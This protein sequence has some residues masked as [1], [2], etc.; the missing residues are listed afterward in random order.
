MFACT[1][2]V[3]DCLGRRYRTRD[4]LS[5]DLAASIRCESMPETIDVNKWIQERFESYVYRG[6][7]SFLAGPTDR[8]NRAWARCMTLLEEERLKGG[9]LDVDTE[10][11][12]GIDEFVPG[13]ILE[14][15]DV[16][17]GLQTDQPL[18]R[19]CKPAGG[20]RMVESSCKA[21]GYEMSAEMLKVFTKYRKTHNMGVFD[22]YDDTMRSVR[23]AHLLTGLPDAYGR[24]RIIGDYRRVAVYGVDTLI[25]SKEMDKRGLGYPMTEDVIRLREELSEQINSLHELKKM[26]SRHGFDISGPATS[27][28]EAVQWTYFGYLGAVKNQDG[29]AMSLGRIDT[30]FDIYIEDDLK[31]GLISETEAQEIIDDFVIK[32][33]LV[34]HLR[35]PAFEALFSG[36]PTWVTAT[37]GGLSPSG[38]PQVTKTSFRLLNTL[39]NLGPAPEPNMTVLWSRKMPDGFK[40]FCADVS[41]RT[42]AVQYENDDIM[43]PVFGSDYSI[44]C[45]VSGMTIGKQMQFFGARCNLPKLL[46]YVINDGRDEI[47]GKQVGP[48]DVFPAFPKDSK[49]DIE[50]VWERF[51]KA[52]DWIAEVYAN[53]MNVIHFMH[54]KYNYEKLEMALHDTSVHR[55]MAYGCAGISAVADSL[56][57]IKYANVRAIRNENGI[58]TGFNVDGEFPKYGNDDDRVDGYAKDVTN[59]FIEKLRRHKT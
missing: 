31:K 13:Y 10:T 53:T 27:A 11:V 17:V 14:G 26:A 19:A 1:H 4:S 18:K 34:R 24:G 22:A 28:K 54:D 33:R 29:A 50:M 37:M 12:S 44:A 2:A 15:E 52:M 25:K 21:Y 7:S 30:F 6:D 38:E 55:F 36:N 9:T 42:S 47:S 8:T 57:A 48:K 46:L 35:T 23:S 41:I 40:R 51:D 58:T 59:R 20:A 3:W 39:I 32:L 56:S 5:S 43:Q 49:L 16:I 45:C